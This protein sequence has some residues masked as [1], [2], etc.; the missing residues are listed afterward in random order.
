MNMNTQEARFYEQEECPVCYEKDCGLPDNAV[1]NTLYYKC[2]TCKEGGYCSSCFYQLNLNKKN[3]EVKCP[4]CRI[5]NWNW[6]LKDILDDYF[7]FYIV[8]NILENSAGISF[9]EEFKPVE[10][11]LLKNICENEGYDYQEILEEEEYFR[12]EEER[13]N[14]RTKDF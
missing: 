12:M 2:F 11:I 6:K 4:C 7:N 8:C 3:T 9:P 1:Y 14:K 10:Y 5:K 13:E